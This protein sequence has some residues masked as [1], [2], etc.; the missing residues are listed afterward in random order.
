SESWEERKQAFTNSRRWQR[1][2]TSSTNQCGA[3]PLSSVRLW[4]SQQHIAQS[5]KTLLTTG[6]L[7]ASTTSAKF[8]QLDEISPTADSLE[9]HVLNSSDPLLEGGRARPGQL[10][11][12]GE[13]ACNGGLLYFYDSPIAELRGPTSNLTDDFVNFEENSK[14]FIT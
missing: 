1:S 10:R 13:T 8:G 5:V 3:V 2:S 4:P 14:N 6:F 7:L 11:L 9:R 12:S